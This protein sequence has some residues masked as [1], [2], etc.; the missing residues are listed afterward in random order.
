[1]A[2]VSQNGDAMLRGPSA[3]GVKEAKE[4][5][6]L[7]K[8]G[9]AASSGDVRALLSRPPGWLADQM[10]HVRREG[11]SENQ[12]KALAG[13]VAAHSIG[14]ATRGGEVLATVEAFMTH[15]LGCDCKECL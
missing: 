14:D 15:G 10:A 5:G 11:T 6:T 9:S 1:M 12:L 4:V 8:S 2:Y 7:N 3:N 13:A